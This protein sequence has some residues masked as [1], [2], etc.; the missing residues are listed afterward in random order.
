MLFHILY[1]ILGVFLY[2]AICLVNPHESCGFDYLLIYRHIYP[3]FLLASIVMPFLR[4][5]RK[6]VTA[7]C[8]YTLFMALPLS[9]VLHGIC[10]HASYD[11]LKFFA[12]IQ[13]VYY[14]PLLMIRL[15]KELT[16]S[17][18]F[19]LLLFVSAFLYIIIWGPSFIYQ[20][21]WFGLSGSGGIS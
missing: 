17:N 19:L 2:I 5:A 8:L 11:Y 10:D 3:F 16:F 7:L 14:L 13:T 20:C 9:L 4:N 15:Y 21:E 6:S 12:V 18:V 1:I